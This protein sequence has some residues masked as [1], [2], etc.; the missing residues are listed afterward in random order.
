MSDRNWRDRAECRPG[1]G[2]DPNLWFAQAHSKRAQAKQIC[3][4]CPVND[5]CHEQ[6]DTATVGIWAGESLTFTGP[7]KSTINDYLEE[8]GTLA[9]YSRHIRRDEIPC[10][11]CSTANRF[12]KSDRQGV[13]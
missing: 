1:G 6:I 2:H 11:R 8:H 3:R 9:G 10:G 4:E 13:A 12:Y 5:M 7:G